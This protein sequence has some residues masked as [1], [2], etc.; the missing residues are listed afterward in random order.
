ML[1]QTR[2]IGWSDPRLDPA[3]DWKEWKEPLDYSE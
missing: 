1:S 2:V 3:R